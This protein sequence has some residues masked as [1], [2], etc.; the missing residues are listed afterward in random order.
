MSL[1]GDGGD[2]LF[3]GYNRY[4]WAA[5]AWRLRQRI[6]GFSRGFVHNCLQN[7]RFGRV[8]NKLQNVL[9]KRHRVRLLDDKLR[10]LAGVLDAD[11]PLNLYQR[12]VTNPHGQNPL[13]PHAPENFPE[14]KGLSFTEQMMYHDLT[15]YLP[16]DILTKVDRAS[17]AVSLE[18]RVPLLDH[19]VAEFA[20]HLPPEMKLKGGVNKWLLREVLYQYVPKKLID[21]PKMGFG[22]P[23]AAWLRGPLKDWA[24][25]LLRESVLEDQGF[26]DAKAVRRLW[27][28]HQSGQGHWQYQLWSVL[29]F[30]SWLAVRN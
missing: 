25:D 5:R 6:P 18:A 16:N 19:R 21:R 30:Q 20:W 4:Q 12:L 8:A 26:L 28:S 15:G 17:M 9:P 27:Q 14:V 1:S 7:A 11:S 29:M 3:C 22:V 2:E 24:E 10:K 23:M 13:M